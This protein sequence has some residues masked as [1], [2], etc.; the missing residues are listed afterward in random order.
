[1][2]RTIGIDL[3]TSNSAG[4][5]MKE[6]K[7]RIVPAAEGPTAYG[8][9]VPSIVAFK[10]DG[11]VLVEKMQR[12]ILTIILIELSSGLKEKSVQIIVRT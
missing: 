1:M 3:G 12:D 4:A 8:K 11:E 7:I 10:D 2:R 6:G 9:M 5:V